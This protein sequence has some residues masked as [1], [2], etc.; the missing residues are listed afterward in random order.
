MARPFIALLILTAALAANAN[1]ATR[2]HANFCTASKRVVLQL[3]NT[4]S[5]LRSTATLVQR[6]AELKTQ[7]TT[8]KSA[9]PA[10]RSSVPARL[11]PKLNAV[12]A[13]ADLI[14]AKLGAVHWNIVAIV[15]NQAVGAQIEAASARADA[16][17][18][19]LKAYYR[20]TCHY[21]V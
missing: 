12:L 20:N 16:A 18:P 4:A 10:L 3:V 15:Q 13:L 6:E 5:A 17:M 2:T 1:A 8:I 19:A 11:K 7:F 9:E 21:K 14:N